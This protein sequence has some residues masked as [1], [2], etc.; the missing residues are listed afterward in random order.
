[1]AGYRLYFMDEQDHIAQAIELECE[2]DLKAIR[3]AEQHL[4]GREVELWR[5]ARVVMRF[6]STHRPS[7]VAS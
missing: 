3:A 6:P 5:R 7:A 1:M 2:D 4:D